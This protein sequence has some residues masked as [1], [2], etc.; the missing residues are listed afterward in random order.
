MKEFD[1]PDSI[2]TV[3]SPQ[4]ETHFYCIVYC[5]NIDIEKMSKN[6]H[7]KLYPMKHPPKAVLR[8]TVIAISYTAF[9]TGNT[10]FMQ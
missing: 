4:S 3:A 9:L 8:L 10:D 2:E 5:S 1:N 7:K 6:F